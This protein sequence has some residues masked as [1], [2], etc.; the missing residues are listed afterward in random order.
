MTFLWPFLVLLMKIVESFLNSSAVAYRG[1][2]AVCPALFV[3]G[4]PSDPIRMT[5]IG[6]ARG[7]TATSPHYTP[8]R[9]RGQE[10]WEHRQWSESDV[11]ST[12]HLKAKSD[13]MSCVK[14]SGAQ[15]SGAV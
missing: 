7:Q 9:H 1:L 4:A 6:A 10:H 11:K 12:A 15:S 2:F 14:V 5:Q 13:L 3:I 8:S